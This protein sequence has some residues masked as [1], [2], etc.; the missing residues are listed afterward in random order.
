MQPN[1]PCT[2]LHKFLRQQLNNSGI[3]II[4]VM[5]P[6]VDTPWHKGDVP[7][8]AISANKAVREMIQKLQSDKKEIRIGAVPLLYWLSRIAPAFAFRKINQVK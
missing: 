4:E 7:K 5:M 1:L 6:V 2:P 3:E 8:I